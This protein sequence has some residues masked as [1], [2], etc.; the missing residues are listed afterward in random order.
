MF[1]AGW[2]TLPGTFLGS[3]VLNVWIGYV[4]AGHFYLT[5]LV[6]ALGIAFASVMQAAVG[7]AVLRKVI[8]YP[9]QFDNSRELSLFLL[10]SPIFCLLSATISIAVLWAL[11]AAQRAD[12]I[13]NWTTWWAGDALGVLVTTA[14]A[15]HGRGAPRAVAVTHRLRCHPNGPLLRPVCGGLCARQ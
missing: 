4:L 7:G 15:N 6:A 5:A 8:G 12:L 11:G 9:A 14:H 1:M 3:F 10:L 2:A 13:T